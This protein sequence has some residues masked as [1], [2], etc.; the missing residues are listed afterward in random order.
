MKKSVIIGIA[1]GSAS[2]KSSISRRLKE[3]YENT[4]SVVIIRQD[5]YYKDQKNKTMEERVKTNYDHPFAFDNDLF[6]AQ[7]KQLMAGVAIEKPVYDFVVHTRSEETEH[8]EPSDVIVIEG[9]F[10]LEDEQLRDLCDIRIFVDTDDDIRFIRRLIRDVKKRGRT[11]DSVIEQYTTTVKVMHNT[12]IEPSRKYADIIIP[13]GGHNQVAID[14]L[15]TKI[16]SIIQENM[17]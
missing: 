1:G 3:R 13:E 17:L 11:I 15:T 5:D 10:I 8:I 6:V 2:G 4:N 16:S 7:L 12:F 14:L 9:L